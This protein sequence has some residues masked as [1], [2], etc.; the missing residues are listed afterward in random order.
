[1]FKVAVK[2]WK[3]QIDGVGGSSHTHQLSNNV[4]ADS[5]KPANASESHISP[6]G[7]ALE[8]SADSGLDSGLST[9]PSHNDHVCIHA[10]VDCLS[11]T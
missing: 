10:F 7:S 9:R 11:H 1:M 3:M 6:Q 4:V 5:A 8:T 2:S